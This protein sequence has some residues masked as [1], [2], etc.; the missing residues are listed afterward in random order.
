MSDHLG[1]VVS[2]C[3]LLQLAEQRRVG[4]EWCYMPNDGGQFADGMMCLELSSE[5]GI[6][7]SDGGGMGVCVPGFDENPLQLR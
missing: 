6:P 4:D 1:L 5:G 2:L 3:G 7:T